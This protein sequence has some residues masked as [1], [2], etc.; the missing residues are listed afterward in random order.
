MQVRIG[1]LHDAQA[2]EREWELGDR[3][4]VPI[5]LQPARLDAERIDACHDG[6]DADALQDATASQQWR[7]GHA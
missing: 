7:A 4:L 2:L 1:D 5:D 6:C 3:N